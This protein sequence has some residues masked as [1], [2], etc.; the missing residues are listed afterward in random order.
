MLINIFMFF[1]TIVSHVFKFLFLFWAIGDSIEK[2][3]IF[4]IFIFI[5]QFLFL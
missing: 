3:P 2:A 1:L 4:V 5:I